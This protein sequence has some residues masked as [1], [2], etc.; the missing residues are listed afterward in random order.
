[1]VLWVKQVWS[2]LQPTGWHPSL[3][4]THPCPRRGARCSGW[5]AAPAALLPGWGQWDGSCP[6]SL[7][8]PCSSWP[9]DSYH[10]SWAP[11]SALLQERP[12]GISAPQSHPLKSAFTS[13][14]D[15][16]SSILPQENSSAF[17]SHSTEG[18]NTEVLRQHFKG[19]LP[20][21]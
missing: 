17:L 18:F 14:S 11:T 20:R 13:G 8:N 4:S 21:L 1:M 10:S 19:A 5:G 15:S 9:P 6:V 16:C 2:W 12:S 3:A 7:R